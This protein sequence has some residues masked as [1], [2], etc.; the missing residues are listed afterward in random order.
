M[1]ETGHYRLLGY[2]ILLLF[3]LI[4][5]SYGAAAS[6]QIP[7]LHFQESG[8]PRSDSY[9]VF[10]QSLPNLTE[11]T[12]CYRLYVF[13]Y[14]KE[15]V[16]VSYAVSDADNNVVRIDHTGQGFRM[17]I[18]GALDVSADDL[19]LRTWRHYCLGVNLVTG[20]WVMAIQ[21]QVTLRQERDPRLI[22]RVIQG[23]GLFVVGQDQDLLGGG[24]QTE[25]S[26][27]GALAEL[28]VWDYTLD[29]F[30]IGQIANLTSNLQGNVINW[31]EAVWEL[32]GAVTE[33]CLD[34]D[35]FQRSHVHYVMLAK[36]RPFKESMQLCQSLKGKVAAPT[37]DKENQ[38]LFNHSAPY[39][40][41]CKNNIGYIYLWVG[42]TDARVEGEWEDSST[43]L[44][45]QYEGSWSPYEPNGE[46]EENCATLYHVTAMWNDITCSRALM[47]TVCQFEHQ[48]KV[49]IL[50]LCERSG[51]DA[52]YLLA[53]EMNGRPFF[54]GNRTSRI[55][56][57]PQRG[58]WV[59]DSLWDN[60][61]IGVMMP[62]DEIEGILPMGSNLW[63][64]NTQLCPG[65]SKVLELTVTA[66]GSGY[67]TCGEGSCVPLHRR[68]DRRTDCPDRS[69]EEHCSILGI[70]NGYRSEI[71][72]SNRNND[73]AALPV[74]VWVDILAL[75]SINTIQ[76]EFTVDFMLK[77]AWHDQR[78]FYYNLKEE[79]DLNNLA[80]EER[81]RIWT[82]S[83]SFT[84]ARGNSHTVLDEEAKIHVLKGGKPLRPS[85]SYAHEVDLF[86]GGDAPLILERKYHVR[87]GCA[88]DLNRYPFD[89]QSCSME[90]ESQ[91]TTSSYMELVPGHVH[92]S[93][94]RQL[95]EYVV[96]EISMESTAQNSSFSGL[97]VQLI[98]IRQSGYHLVATYLPTSIMIVIA[99]LSFFFGV[100]DFN[101]RIMVSLTSLLVLSSL[102]TQT[103]ETLPKTSYFKMVDI[104]LFFCI[105]TIFTVI[106]IHTAS[107]YVDRVN[108]EASDSSL[109][110]KGHNK[111]PVGGN[112]VRFTPAGILSF[113]KVMVPFTVGVFN[114]VYWIIA[115]SR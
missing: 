57:C 84:S 67:Y 28:Q 76:M 75:T 44:P 52:H 42:Y 35:K 80:N 5:P 81:D 13:F 72:P 20:D 109:K 40:P 111:I 62:M 65:A 33:H 106:L 27:S 45:L 61:T 1:E 54:S 95:V 101:D 100:E 23:G 53:G 12:L 88:F 50:G 82:P 83:V 97:Q 103:S 18:A 41:L 7:V 32:N 92:F 51:L 24:F 99:Y 78:L 29:E 17:I 107:I 14:R 22:N 115:L 70:S 55:F 86:N 43:G 114:I 66:C 30:T 112:R 71:P 37:S 10:P 104:W 11:F 93:G 56:W 102:L 90:F 47:C 110:G 77:M 60:K 25:Q 59:M 94:R 2:Q 98:F 108:Q 8:E 6:Q 58:A 96:G 21:G 68:C 73:S 91:F 64:F 49:E 87:Y 3:L 9:A 15:I 89:T 79:V 34:K 19:P 63:E 113:G 38:E 74:L 105:V 85:A 31:E 4:S 69:D 39:Y 48:V 26:L 36:R 46:R 16:V